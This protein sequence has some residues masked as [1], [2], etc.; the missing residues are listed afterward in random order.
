VIISSPFFSKE[1]EVS[2]KKKKYKSHFQKKS[3][4]SQYLKRNGG[5]HFEDINTKKLKETTIKIILVFYQRKFI[6]YR[7]N[8]LF[9]ILFCR[10]SKMWLFYGDEKYLF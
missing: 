5:L 9:E 2:F 4:S 8:K 10:N 1:I 6:R 3:D 7:D